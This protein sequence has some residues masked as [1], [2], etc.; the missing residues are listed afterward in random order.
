M[1]SPCTH[2]PRALKA[3][4]MAGLTS[5]ALLVAT[6]PSWA[7]GYTVQ[8][9]RSPGP[10]VRMSNN[11]AVAGFFVA[12]CVT[13]SSQPKRTI[14]YNAPWVFDGQRVTK[15]TNKFPSNVNAMP[16]AVND[17]LEL[18]GAEIYGAW[19]YSNGS[20]AY[21]D[22]ANPDA[23]GT[24]LVALNNLGVALG[25][26]SLSG[27]YQPVT[28]RY[29]GVLT[30]VLTPGMA[31]VDINDAGMIAG[32]YKGADN[33]D[34]SFV[35]AGG[36]IIDIPK[37]D[38]ATPSSCQPVRI[39][40]VSASGSAW[41]AGHCSGRPYIYDVGSGALIELGNAAGYT[42][43]SVQSVN[44]N[45]VAAGTGIRPGAYAPDG[46]TAVMWSNHPVIGYSAPQDLNALQPFAPAGAWNLHSIDINEAGTILT[47]YNDISGNFYT[48]QLFPTP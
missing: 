15:L 2:I 11:G 26:T 17:S 10:A 38:P 29:N 35:Y 34:Q 41:V 33:T 14:C 4:I 44:G 48:F 1:K 16:T 24:R 5:A 37:L 39:S 23:R 22:S 45:G 3:A 40:Q 47:G 28:Y 36:T 19:F 42:S 30:P 7:A 8:E 12:K 20:V 27:V 31:A 9:I 13:L 25:M 6:P 46:Y 43:L 32:W 21:P 18:T